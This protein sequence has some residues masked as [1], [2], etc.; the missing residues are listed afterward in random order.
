MLYEGMNY[1][2]A[3]ER[4]PKIPV[5]LF[6]HIL[7]YPRSFLVVLGKPNVDGFLRYPRIDRTGTTYSKCGDDR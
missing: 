5:F 3:G 1:R 2:G 4:A 6:G 7:D